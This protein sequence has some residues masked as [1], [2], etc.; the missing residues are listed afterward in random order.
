MDATKSNEGLVNGV[1][2]KA[3]RRIFS[4]EKSA[5]C[6]DSMRAHTTNSVKAV[7]KRTNSIPAVIPGGTTKYLQPLD[8]SVNQAFIAALKGE[9]EAWFTI[10]DKSFTKTGSMQRATFSGVC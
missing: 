8:V 10:A 9:W 6:L 5:D 3:P 2:Q 7:I 4:L 1:L